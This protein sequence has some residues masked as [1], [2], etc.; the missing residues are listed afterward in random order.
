MNDFRKL[1]VKINASNFS[2]LILVFRF[3]AFWNNRFVRADIHCFL[4]LS[5]FLINCLEHYS[6]FHH[7]DEGLILKNWPIICVFCE[8]KKFTV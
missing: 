6:I 3:L 2:Y 5:T 4:P 1:K 7:Y 8:R